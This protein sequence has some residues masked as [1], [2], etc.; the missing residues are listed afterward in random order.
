MVYVATAIDQD[1]GSN[2]QVAFSFG[3]GNQDGKFS[4]QPL[5]GVITVAGKLSYYLSQYYQV[6]IIWRTSHVAD[7]PLPFGKGR[8]HLGQG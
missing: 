6:S 1:I 5:T 7:N 3:A 4:I 2:G 8:H